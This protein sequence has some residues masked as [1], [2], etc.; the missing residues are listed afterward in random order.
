M[1]I[2]GIEMS[3]I[4]DCYRQL[5]RQLPDPPKRTVIIG[6]DADIESLKRSLPNRD[7]PIP[8]GLSDLYGVPVES[9]VSR[10]KMFMRAE[11]LYKEV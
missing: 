6:M 9:Y 3:R 1:T 8:L 5:I 7:R 11:E 10:A 2:A 4:V